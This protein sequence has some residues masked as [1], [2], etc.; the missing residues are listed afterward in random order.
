MRRYISLMLLMSLVLVGC[1]TASSST[2]HSTPSN[3]VYG[4][5]GNGNLAAYN[6]T[7]GRT[8]WSRRL[9]G[10][11][12]HLVTDAQQWHLLVVGDTVYFLYQYLAAY[13]ATDGKQLWQIPISEGEEH[14]GQL[15]WGGNALFAL[16]TPASTSVVYA[17]NPRNGARIWR[18]P[19]TNLPVPTGDIPPDEANAATYHGG[20]IYLATDY[21]A[22]AL[23]GSDGQL[24]WDTFLP[25]GCSFNYSNVAW[26]PQAL[27]LQS[28][29]A[30]GVSG[31]TSIPNVSYVIAVDPSNGV[32]LWNNFNSAQSDDYSAI[33]STLGLY[34][35]TDT[36]ID[37]L[38]LANGQ[39]YWSVPLS[40][41]DGGASGITQWFIGPTTLVVVTGPTG[42]DLVALSAQSGTQLWQYQSTDSIATLAVG[43]TAA[44]VLGSTGVQAFSLAVGTPLWNQNQPG[45]DQA[46]Q[47]TALQNRVLV[48]NPQVT[49]GGPPACAS[50]DPSNGKQLWTS[51]SN[52]CAFLY[53]P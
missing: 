12:G 42:G 44:Y 38:N 1:A 27:L 53:P 21:G 47:I 39:R 51:D 31:N 36:A 23:N 22:A 52:D 43:D 8:I 48:T 32:P 15:V 45:A 18:Q 6:A 11:P 37:S 20:T 28:G 30:S 46:L 9:T 29:D 33:T 2:S 35:I 25:C 3:V 17:L 49:I 26:I 41:V 50:L 10:N 14:P 13:R 16:V 40:H 24:L 5:N 7:T 34:A 19:L 4:L